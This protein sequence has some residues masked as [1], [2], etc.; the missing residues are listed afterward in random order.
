MSSFKVFEIFHKAR[1][2]LTEIK[3]ESYLLRFFYVFLYFPE[4]I[5]PE[6]LMSKKNGQIID[7]RETFKYKNEFQ[8]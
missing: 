5:D 8:Q 1:N 7:S 3:A 2:N 6:R 4:I